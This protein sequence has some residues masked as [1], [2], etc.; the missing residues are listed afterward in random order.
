M[1]QYGG[2]VAIAVTLALAALGWWYTERRRNVDHEG[3]V[4]ALTAALERAKSDLLSSRRGSLARFDRPGNFTGY[5]STG[6]YRWK[7]VWGDLASSDTLK[8]YFEFVERDSVVHHM[9]CFISLPHVREK[10]C[11]CNVERDLDEVCQDAN[12][13]VRVLR[14]CRAL[15]LF[16]EREEPEL[17]EFL[18]LWRK[19]PSEVEVASDTLKQG[20]QS[21]AG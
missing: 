17:T 13:K 16:F 7:P 18:R 2:R 10:F 8:D 3:T 15:R 20:A 9:H 6:P 21:N 14:E 19:L 12:L 1:S 11:G 5:P 4:E